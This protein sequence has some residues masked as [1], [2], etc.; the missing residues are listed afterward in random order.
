[1]NTC[2]ARPA[3]LA[4]GCAMLLS[5]LIGGCSHSRLNEYHKSYTVT[6]RANVQVD[7]RWG[8]VRVS[9]TPGSQVEFD[10]LYDQ[11]D[12]GSDPPVRSRQDADVVALSAQERFGESNWW[13]GWGWGDDNRHR[14]EIAVR[15]PQDADVRVHTTNGAIDIA[16][17]NGTISI[18]TR[19]GRID[20]QRL[21]GNIDIGSTNGGVGLD[22]VKGTLSVHTTNGRV[23]ASH[24]DGKCELATSNG[25]VQI[26]GRFESLDLTS[27]N[28]PV[29]AR[30]ERG[31]T[32][33]SDWGIHT[34]NGGINLELPPDLKADLKIETT[35][36]GIKLD[37][38]VVTQGFEGRGRLQGSLNG[39][40]PQLSLS[41]TN[42]GIHVRGI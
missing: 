22:T 40:G 21:S 30:A 38:P 17:V 6:G 10:V 37:L 34:T 2:S 39:G 1:M 42:A 28:G 3:R 20:A 36:G 12:L 11:Q 29:V 25:G 27:T 5:A 41:T 13:N 19:N 7:A 15:M 23:I 18:Q 26:E 16:S 35:N 4:V 24:I 31:S 8:A 9:S 33:S 32:M 14:L